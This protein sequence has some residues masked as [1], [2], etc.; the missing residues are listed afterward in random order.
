MVGA[1]VLAVALARTGVDDEGRGDVEAGGNPIVELALHVG[2]QVDALVVGSRGQT[3]LVQ[4]AEGE[5]VLSGVGGAGDAHVVALLE[6]GAVGI[7]LPV[8]QA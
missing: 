2:A 4:V 7:V 6:G 8:K 3:V 5:H 1:G